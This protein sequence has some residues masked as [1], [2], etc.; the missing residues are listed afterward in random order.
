MS[1]EDIDRD[2][3]DEDE[4]EAEQRP[5]RGWWSQNWRWFLPAL[6][7]AIV[8][9]GGGAIYWALYTRV[10]DLEPCRAAMQ[11][12][13]ADKQLQEALGEPIRTVKCPSKSTLPSAR[14]EEQ[15]TDILWQ[16]E[17][18]KGA[19]EA[20]V[21]AR[22]MAGKWEIVVLDVKLADGRKIQPQL[23]GGGEAE[24]PTFSAPK[25]GEKKAESKAPPPEIN[26]PVPPAGEPGK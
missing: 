26:L 21:R 7:L 23:A 19:A 16:I 3:R 4:E 15:E 8:I 6:L 14:V 11:A 1:K 9:L 22:M 20:H 25:A 5:R 12:I 24:A 2:A 13:E 17:G 10:Y 18:P